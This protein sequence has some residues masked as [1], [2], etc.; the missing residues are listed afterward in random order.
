MPHRPYKLKV[1]YSNDHGKIIDAASPYAL[2][3]TEHTITLQWSA[4]P[5]S[6][7]SVPVSF[8]MPA[9]DSLRLK[10]HIEA[11]FIEQTEPIQVE[12]RLASS[13]TRRTV[14]SRDA[15]VLVR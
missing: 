12:P 3:S 8:K 4:F 15:T 9:R 14:F 5:D 1:S 13:I 6:S 2:G 10:E 11:V 7:L